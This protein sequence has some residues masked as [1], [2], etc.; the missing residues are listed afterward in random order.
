[1]IE[2]F[3][4][5]FAWVVEHV[6]GLSLVASIVLIVILVTVSV[7]AFTLYKRMKK[8]NT[9]GDYNARLTNIETQNVNT[10]KTL[11]EIKEV[12]ELNKRKIDALLEALYLVYGTLKN[13]EIRTNVQNIL[14]VAKNSEVSKFAE[15]LNELSALKEKV[16][17][18]ASTI[19]EG[20]ETVASVVTKAATGMR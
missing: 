19:V 18:N 10:Q 12:D 2:M 9:S 15:L 17:I 4:N 14:T 16:K 7:V 13:E 3:K 11:S 8:S 1:M 6:Q 20:A 5:L